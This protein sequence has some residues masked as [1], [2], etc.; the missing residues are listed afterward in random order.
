MSASRFRNR[1]FRTLSGIVALAVAYIGIVAI[2]SLPG[3]TPPQAD[4]PGTASINS[5]QTTYENWSRQYSE[6]DPA[7][8]VLTLQYSRGL[9]SQYNP[10]KGIAQ[11]DLSRNRISVR[12]RGLTDQTVSDVWLIDNLPGDSRTV[13]PEPGDNMRM[14]GQLEFS[15]GNALLDTHIDDLSEFDLDMITVSRQGRRPGRDGVLFGTTSLFQKMY[16]YPEF[17]MASNQRS[18]P[19]SQ[20]M[21]LISD[22]HA[23]G[24]TPP[25]YFPGVDSDLLNEGRDLFFNGTFNGNGRT[26]GTCHRENDNLALSLKTI[27]SLPAHDPLFIVEQPFR[28]DGTANALYNEFRMEKPALMRKVGLIVENLNGFRDSDGEFTNR[29]V[30][31]APNHVLSVRTTLAPPPAQAFDD[32]TLPVDPDDLLFAERTGWSGDGTPSGF[33]EDFFESNGR[34]LTGSL[35]DFAI[36]ATVQHFPLTL[37]RSALSVDD[38]GNPREPDFRFPTEHELDA[39]EAFMLSIGRQQENDDLDTIALTDELADRGRL[40]YLGFNVFDSTPDDGRPPLNCNACHLNGGSNTDPQF[41]FPSAVTPN[42]DLADLAANGGSIPSHNRSFGPQ[43][44]RLA[45]QA[46][47]VIAQVVDDP[48]VDGNCFNLGLAE[49]PLLPGDNPAAPSDG[50]DVNLIDNGFGFGFDD[51]FA[52]QRLA[53]NRFN[54]PVVFES[55]DNPP[56]FHGH[57][58]NTVEGAVAF[59]ATNRLLR[60]GEFLPAIVPLN[61]AQVANVARFMRVMGADFNAESAI[62]LLDKANDL[63]RRGDRITNVRLALAE[64]DDAIELLDPVD[65]HIDDAVPLLEFARANLQIASFSGSRFW[66]NRAA[67]YLSGAQDAMIVRGL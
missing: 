38:M 60:N 63:R 55:V 62:T 8:P 4:M 1:T 49:I 13:M 3:S 14:I 6:S 57:Q 17:A 34:D 10:A 39:M 33:R 9:S 52:D 25:G 24:L 18:E 56:F 16:H 48:S 28:L 66:I 26:C 59:Y 31:R 64:V 20:S 43:V 5:L 35:R 12:I 37:E 7:G 22:A 15:D 21:W 54:V 47:D 61:G 19:E 27:A 42:H 40:N 51:A 45:D 2:Q 32:G 50:C 30:M 44:D 67:A 36:G 11:L 46:G 41:P 65:I 58:I 53:T 23:S 29:V